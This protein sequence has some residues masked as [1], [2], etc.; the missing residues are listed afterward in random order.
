MV[1]SN[2]TLRKNFQHH[3]DI[4]NAGY[5]LLHFPSTQVHHPQHHVLLEHPKGVN[6]SMHLE[7]EP[8][9]LLTST[10]TSSTT[11][12]SYKN[13]SLTSTGANLQGESTRTT[14]NRTS[15]IKPKR[16]N[17]GNKFE[18]NNFLD[19]YQYSEQW[20]RKDSDDS[21]SGMPST[22][23]SNNSAMKTSRTSITFS[24]SMED[25][26]F[27]GSDGEQSYTLLDRN[28]IKYLRKGDRVLIVVDDDEL[29]ITGG[30][31]CDPTLH[32]KAGN[33][34]T[35]NDD[36]VE[37]ELK[38][39]CSSPTVATS[40][41]VFFGESSDN[42][43]KTPTKKSSKASISSGQDLSVFN[44]QFDVNIPLLR[45]RKRVWV[46]KFCVCLGSE[47]LKKRMQIAA[48]KGSTNP[49][50][51]DSNSDDDDV[52]NDEDNEDDEEFDYNSSGNGHQM[53]NNSG[54][55]YH[56][57]PPNNDLGSPIIRV[58]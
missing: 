52:N 7:Q 17:L 11:T 44:S 24:P 38:L 16:L 30:A 22:R 28:S 18:S 26:L 43:K 15:H 2:N 51:K 54:C 13:K 32:G 35:I 46:P 48:L 55:R 58:G 8:L 21:L 39:S 37:V 34:C 40:S 23:K 14:P 45:Q 12:P 20:Q 27:D 31:F 33:V 49:Y 19:N 1:T 6:T 41:R 25:C 47:V 4:M 3:D 10:T 29:G 5:N 42:I 36:E 56:Q 53:N 50:N 57:Q 9:F